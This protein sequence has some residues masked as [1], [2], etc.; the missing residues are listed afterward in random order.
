MP[1]TSKSTVLSYR[2]NLCWVHTA[3]VKFDLVVWEL[4][5][6]NLYLSRTVCHRHETGERHLQ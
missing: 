2:K 1:F 3:T 6:E 5:P 4:K